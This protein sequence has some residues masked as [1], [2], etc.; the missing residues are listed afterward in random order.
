MSK[1]NWND[2]TVGLVDYIAEHSGGGG[3]GTDLLAMHYTGD[4]GTTGPWKLGDLAVTSGTYV[5]FLADVAT[6][7]DMN[8]GVNVIFFTAD[9]T[10]I[11]TMIST[12][13]TAAA[14]SPESR[15]TS[16]R[17]YPE[18]GNPDLL[19][20]AVTARVGT[21]TRTADPAKAYLHG[22]LSDGS[23]TAVLPVDEYLGVGDANGG[24]RPM[25]S[26]QTGPD[27]GILELVF[28]VAI[29]AADPVSFFIDCY[30][31][32]PGTLLTAFGFDA[33]TDTTVIPFNNT[34]NVLLRSTTKNASS[35][36][37]K[38]AVNNLNLYWV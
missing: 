3:G 11:A 2:P 27:F 31:V 30:S 1:Y 6:P 23:T 26:C 24:V 36:A 17:S 21:F 18:P 32:A 4:L 16:L 8:I 9:T 10:V 14:P 28:A 15:S 22:W 13:I 20:D 12:A 5:L 37:H 33:P 25:A 29:G 38:F 34:Y 19:P 35:S 7:G